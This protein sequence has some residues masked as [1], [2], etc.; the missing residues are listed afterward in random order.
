MKVLIEKNQLNEIFEILKREYKIV[1]PVLKDNVIQLSYV[2]N[3]EELPFGY[4]EI[5]EKN[6]YRVEKSDE[7]YLFTYV[8][9][10]IPYKRYL[11]PPEFTFLKVYK[12]NGK[13]RF[14]EYKRIEK[15]AFF[16]IRSCDLKGISIL[17]DVFLYK[18]DFPDSFYKEIRENLFIV[19]VSCIKPSNVCFCASIG[20]SPKPKENFDILITELEDKLLIETKTEKGKDVVKKLKYKMATEE[21]IK[22]AEEIEKIC[23]DKMKRK[24]DINGFSEIL[25]KNIES[26]IWEEIGKRCLACTSCTQLCPTCFCFDIIERNDIEKGISER[27]RIYD[28]CFNPSFA[29]VHKFNIRES[30][31]SRYR[32]WYMHKFAYWKDQF[33]QIG[34]VG[35]GR[36]ITWCPA[37]IDVTEE[38]KIIRNLK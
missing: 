35:C 36:C 25:Y 14:E 29:T 12:E 19:A 15:L 38:E 28:S 23:I 27:V 32:Q 3:I 10:S 9:P 7:N 26:S 33:N 34:C 22:K 13:L 21:E 31:A 30:I 20:I 18:N 5:E 1:A 8:R 4:E 16:D 6:F 37:Y 17:D 24:M 11:N 2:E